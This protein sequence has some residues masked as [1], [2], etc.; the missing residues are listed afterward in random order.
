MKIITKSVMCIATG[1]I[2]EEESFEYNGPVAECKSGGGSSTEY[3]QSPEQRRIYKEMLPVIRSI[4]ESAETG[5]PAYRIPGMPVLPTMPSA[6]GVYSGVPTYN[7]PKYDV[8]TYNIPDVGMMLPSTQWYEGLSPDVKASIMAPYEEAGERLISNM[9]ARGQGGSPRGGYSG[10][11]GAAM[12]ELAAEAGKN[13]GLQTWQMTAPQLQSAW[14]AELQKRAG[15][16]EDVLDI[17]KWL[18]QQQ[19]AQNMMSY[20]NLMKEAGIDY[21]T[22][23]ALNEMGYTRD[24]TYRNEIANLMGMPF[25]IAPSLLGGTYSTPVVDQGGAS[26]FRMLGSA[27]SGAGMMGIAAAMAPPSAGLSVPLMAGLGGFGGLLSGM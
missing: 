19:L 16:T 1:E 5:V 2:L 13:L 18:A 20:E 10:A 7:I 23:R 14:G 26:P 9:L 3:V 6:M 11:M 25:T 8:P 21:E 12:G 24:M 27:A 15:L 17:N 4:A 22:Q